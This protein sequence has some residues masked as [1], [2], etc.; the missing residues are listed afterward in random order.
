MWR[1]IGSSTQESD[2]TVDTLVRIPEPRAVPS[3][4]NVHIQVFITSISK[5]INMEQ[6]VLMQL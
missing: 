4:R 1:A 3:L 5:I 6:H 2:P